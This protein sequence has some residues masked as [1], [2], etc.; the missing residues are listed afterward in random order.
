MRETPKVENFEDTETL[1]PDGRVLFEATLTPHRSLS[2][3]GEALLVGVV[4]ACLALPALLFLRLGAWP[5]IPF[6][7]LDLVLVVWALKASFRH[8]RLYERVRVT[9]AALGIVRVW[10]S[11]RAESW[12]FS[13]ALTRIEMAPAGNGRLK[14][15]C[16]SQSL[17][18]GGF[19]GPDERESLAHALK[20]AL[21][22][23]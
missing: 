19:L 16:G 6:L 11:G 14:L 23:R 1:L 12:R 20:G 7:G 15:T 18:L 8:A 22:A 10:P 17:V 13:P 2:P 4:V 21:R 9:P 3:H 5:V